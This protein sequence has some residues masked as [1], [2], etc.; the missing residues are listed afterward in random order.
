[1]LI[2]IC[3]I[4][5]SGYGGVSDAAFPKSPAKR[6]ATI[7]ARFRNTVRPRCGPGRER[8]PA[9]RHHRPNA[10]VEDAE[11]DFRPREFYA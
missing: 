7:L 11:N 3:L 8:H 10:A 1:M 9:R 5:C 2:F 4:Y 6:A